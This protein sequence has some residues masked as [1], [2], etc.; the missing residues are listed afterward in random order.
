[1]RE[2]ES[3]R[4]RIH[5]LQLEHDILKKANELLKKDQGIDPQ[6]LTNREK[7]L[8]VD[9]LRTTYGLSELLEQLQM[10]RS[11]YFYHRARL[12]VAREV[13]RSA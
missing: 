13:R 3:L 6:D 2:V 9:A 11:S 12:R 10:P 1:M 7:T 8:L 5:R 4:K